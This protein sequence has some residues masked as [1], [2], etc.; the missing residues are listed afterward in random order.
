[1]YYAAC[2]HYATDTSVGFANTW[3]IRSFETKA[4]R[5]DFVSS[6][7]DMA[8]RAIKRREIKLYITIGT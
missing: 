8:T 2:N 4:K 5:N 1:M 6:A 7:E 3:Y